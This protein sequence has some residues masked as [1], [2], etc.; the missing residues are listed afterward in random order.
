MKIV[1]C[2]YKADL[3]RGIS[4]EIDRLKR[5]L[6]DPE[7]VVFEYLDNKQELIQTLRDADAVINTYVNLDREILSQCEQLK[8]IALNAVG[9]DMVDVQAATDYRILVCPAAE[10]CT[11]EVAEHTFALIFALCRGLR[12]HINEIEN[13]VWDY[14][15]AGT[16]ER[17]SGKTMTIFG[18]GKIGKAVATRGRALGLKIQVVSQSLTA[19]EARKLEVSLV[20]WE[21][22][23]D[24]S[25][26]LSNHMALRPDTTGFFNLEKFKRCKKQPLFINTGRGKTVVE[27][28]L[29][30]ALDSGYLSGAGLDV[31]ADENGD[32]SGLALLGRDNVIVTPHAGFFS[33]ES[34]RD[35][36]DISCDS[37]VAALTGRYEDISKIINREQIKDKPMGE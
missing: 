2:D 24:T 31:L 5:E 29:V 16:V 19:D 3:G 8:C 35:L 26:I 34:A 23:M 32:I 13:H 7:I 17:I 14:M 9:Y 28:D 11:V 22:A 4:Y 30:L 20:D 27:D 33:V 18:F 37:V 21:Q 6:P 15:R 1:I 12:K 25:D 36:Q 10:Y